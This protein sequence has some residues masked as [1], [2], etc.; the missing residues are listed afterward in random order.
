MCIAPVPIKNPAKFFKKETAMIDVPCGSCIECRQSRTHSWYIRLYEELKTATSADFITLTYDSN[1]LP[2][3]EDTGEVSLNY[4][5][6][7]R[8]WKRLRSYT[9]KDHIR[10]IKYYACGEYGTK[11]GRPHYHA[12]VFNNPDKNAYERA[13][14]QG[15][16]HVGEANSATIYYT[17]K[18]VVKRLGKIRKSDHSKVLERGL[19]SKNLGIDFINNES[20][21]Y[22]KEHLTAG[23]V[24]PGG[25]TYPL[26]KYY[27]QKIFTESERKARA[28]LLEIENLDRLYK[29]QMD[30][31][32][33][34]R[35]QYK[36][37]ESERK[38]YETD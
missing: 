3:I 21:K 30:P 32:R 1:N 22:Y 23:Y 20:K 34:Q 29:R 33:K 12:I 8:F 26:P 18:Y 2:I 7:Q 6:L 36:E 28:S 31:L 35:A 37:M 13:W 16:T 4:E 11:T 19:M 24:L 38:N 25:V 14:A 15:L 10:K 17:L 5:D 9:P 27:V